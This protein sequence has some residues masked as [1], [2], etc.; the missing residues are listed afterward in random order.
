MY[1]TT[2]KYLNQEVSFAFERILLVCF[3]AYFEEVLG[4]VRTLPEGT[5]AINISGSGCFGVL[6]GSLLICLYFLQYKESLSTTPW[7]DP[8][9]IVAAA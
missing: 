5:S 9:H 2:Y 3:H 6:L 4:C 7:C 1:G 8:P